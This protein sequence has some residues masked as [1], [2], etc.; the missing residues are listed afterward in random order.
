MS[1]S[2]VPTGTSPVAERPSLPLTDAEGNSHLALLCVTE[3]LDLVGS[4]R[5]LERARSLSRSSRCV[6]AD[7]THSEYLDSSGVRALLALASELQA[8]G[9]D[10]R[11]VIQPDSRVERTLKLLLLLDHFEVFPTLSQACGRTAS[12]A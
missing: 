9:K 5:F 4:Q 8:A 11:L 10:L 12:S 7:L 6:V 1:L 3:A 2:A